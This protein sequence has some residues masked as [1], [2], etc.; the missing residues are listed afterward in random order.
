MKPDREAHG[1]CAYWNGVTDRRP[2]M[3]RNGRDEYVARVIWAKEHGDIPK[4]MMVCH[5][6]DNPAC[7]NPD[8][9]FLGSSTDNVRDSID[10]HRA[11]VGSP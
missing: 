1:P 2:T 9:L 10:K 8:H 3:K 6:C 5:K 4:F 11:F 7:I